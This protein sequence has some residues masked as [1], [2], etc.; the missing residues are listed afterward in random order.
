MGFVTATLLLGSAGDL[1]VLRSRSKFGFRS[2]PSP[3]S[4]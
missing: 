1:G 2:V 4:L 3:V